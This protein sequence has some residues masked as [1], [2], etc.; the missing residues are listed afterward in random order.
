VPLFQDRIINHALAT[1]L[2]ADGP[3]LTALGIA[4]ALL[5]LL[6]VSTGAR[7]LRQSA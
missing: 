4:V 3:W 2:K 1:G 6:L 5:I 7:R